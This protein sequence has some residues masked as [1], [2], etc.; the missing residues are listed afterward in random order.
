MAPVGLPE[1]DGVGRCLVMGIVNVTPDSFSD[2]G[3]FATPDDAVAAGLGMLDDGA[4]LLD[5][6][7]EST[8]PGALPVAEADEL[9]RVLPVVE[10]L[11]AA[12][13]IVS[14]DTQRSAVAR[15][16]VQA[17]ARIINDVSGGTADPD[18]ARTVAELG[19][20]YICMYST[21]PAASASAPVATDRQPIGQV[22]GGLRDR[23]AALL[24]AGIQREQIIV[25]P[26]LGFAFAG[27]PNW[28]ILAQI[29]QLAALGYPVLVGASRKRFLADA[30]GE[31][32]TNWA[33]RDAATV[34]VT[35]LAAAYGAWAVRVH[36]VRPN[37][38]AARV[39]AAWNPI[40]EGQVR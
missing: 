12:G 15:A 21:G 5:I 34:A 40:T 1:F 17:G 8:R 32:E 25:D 14:V 19:V 38:V 26:G 6:G 29:D 2:G 11:A 9:A 27:A 4:D 36:S 22:V 18:M 20:P 10:C 3:R 33:S 31:P 37:A 7:G 24:K 30:T 39:A 23:V 13:A 28:E 16:C 35:A